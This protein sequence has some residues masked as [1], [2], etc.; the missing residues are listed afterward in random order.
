MYENFHTTLTVALPKQIRAKCLL[1]EALKAT[2]SILERRWIWATWRYTNILIRYDYRAHKNNFGIQI[3]SQLFWCLFSARQP[4]STSLFLSLLPLSLARSQRREENFPL[5]EKNF[6]LAFTHTT[7]TFCRVYI[8]THS[9]SY[10]KKEIPRKILCK[11]C[12]KERERER[13]R[14]RSKIRDLW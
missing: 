2:L 4:S 3:F 14:K 10:K 8:K 1:Q 6:P 11:G 12:G 9:L 5:F 13:V 7:C